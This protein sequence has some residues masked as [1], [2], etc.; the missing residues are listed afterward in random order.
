M[1][2]IYGPSSS[3]VHRPLEPRPEAIAE[4]PVDAA[5][6]NDIPLARL[7]SNRQAPPALAPAGDTRQPSA[8]LK[9]YSEQLRPSPSLARQAQTLAHALHTGKPV[10]DNLDQCQA[11]MIL[12]GKYLEEHPRAAFPIINAQLF[13]ERDEQ[14]RFLLPDALA[15]SARDTRLQLHKA[16]GE[17]GKN[18]GAPDLAA[19]GQVLEQ[20]ITQQ[21]ELFAGK[22]AQYAEVLARPGLPEAD[23]A[24]VLR[25]EQAFARHAA[26]VANEIPQ[27]LKQAQSKAQATVDALRHLNQ[28]AAEWE[29]I[30]QQLKELVKQTSQNGDFKDALDNARLPVTLADLHQANDGWAA[31]TKAF[32]AGAVPQMLASGLAFGFARA[33]VEAAIPDNLPVQLFA[34][35]AVMAAAHEVGTNLLKPMGQELVGGWSLAP[36]K[37]S[38]VIPNPNPRISIG[39]VI[40][41]PDA[42]AKAQAKTAVET[43]RGQHKNAQQANKNGTG[44]G[45]L[46]AYG[47]FATAQAIRRGLGFAA[48]QLHVNN[49]GPRTLASM[50]GGVLMGGVQSSM[51]LRSTATD[52]RGRELPTHTFKQVDKPLSQRL[53][54]AAGDAVLASNPSDTEVRQSLLSKTFGSYLGL[55]SA[56]LVGAAGR[57]VGAAGPAQK[58]G[59][60]MLAAMGSPALLIPAYAS[61]QSGPESKAHSAALKAR[62][63]S[64]ALPGAPAESTASAFPRTRSAVQNILDP[65]RADLAH[66]T[67]PGT[68]GRVAENTFHRVRGGLQVASQVP[69]ELIEN[70]PQLIKTAPA[71]LAG[72]KNSVQQAFAATPATTEESD[73]PQP[74]GAYP[75]T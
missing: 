71:A 28:P 17:L 27:A 53:A 14:G 66:G 56:A 4:A 1:S 6:S 69:T 19:Y 33:A 36:V 29:G 9:T 73:D 31:T 60:V 54:K 3:T 49:V 61:F 51:Q 67:L 55:G 38:E 42:E 10:L 16:L 25:S 68:A 23:R 32:V 35:G 21:T 70:A 30:N 72:L 75:A 62:A 13:P 7:S 48:P 11:R 43:L 59:Q 2:S 26:Q 8:T 40:Q 46:Q 18:P 34:T 5:N 12:E 24:Q 52:E 57:A 41:A 45:E 20:A 50:G 63:D 47:S 64:Q 39:G 22:A 15:D 65:D 37:A 44:L 58:F 74:P